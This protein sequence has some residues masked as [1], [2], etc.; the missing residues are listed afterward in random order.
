MRYSDTFQWGSTSLLNYM[1]YMLSCLKLYVLSCSTYL[2]PY[3]P[4]VSR[5]SRVSRASC[6]TCLVPGASCLK[7]LVPYV[8]RAIR[9]LVSHMSYMLLFLTCLV[10]RVL[11]GCLCLKLYML[12]CSS[13]LTCFRCFKPNML[14]YI[15]CLVAFIPCFSWAFG[16]RLSEF[17]YS[18][19]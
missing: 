6:L 19:D 10:L 12:L 5:A 3:V 15:S 18:L 17:F 1:P 4:C 11:S 8:L 7:C 14:L 9:A 2:V 13:Y 16:A